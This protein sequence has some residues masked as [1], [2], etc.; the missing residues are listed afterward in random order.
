LELWNDNHFEQLSRLVT[1]VLSAKS[2]VMKFADSASNFDQ[3]TDK[4][5][6]YIKNVVPEIPDELTLVTSQCLM[7][8]FS[9]AN[10]VQKKIYSAWY[11]SVRNSKLS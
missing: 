6:Q 2:E 5:E 8:D 3:L 1:E 10:D 4:L 11:Q 9:L 7:R